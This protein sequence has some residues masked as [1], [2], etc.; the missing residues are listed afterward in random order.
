MDPLTQAFI[1]LDTSK[2]ATALSS[3]LNQNGF[4][5][6]RFDDGLLLIDEFDFYIRALRY[7][8]PLDNQYLAH[9]VACEREYK[10]YQY[11][12]FELLT[13][14]LQQKILS[15]GYIDEF[16]NH[17]LIAAVQTKDLELIQHAIR[18][19]PHLVNIP[20]KFGDRA[21]DHACILIEYKIAELLINAGANPDLKSGFDGLPID[22]LT[23]S[24]ENHPEKQVEAGNILLLLK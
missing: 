9:A 19:Y 2:F 17:S 24:S 23:I 3:R 5:H 8:V 10:Q 4:V 11:S 18:L 6:P 12:N 7:R 1:S 15:S 13:L 21:L 22:W 20:G 16:D 14:E